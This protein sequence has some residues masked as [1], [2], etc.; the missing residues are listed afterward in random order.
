M[1]L[2]EVISN[3]LRPS[4][5]ELTLGIVHSTTDHRSQDQQNLTKETL[6]SNNIASDQANMDW[7]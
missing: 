1:H 7:L 2:A 3:F 4:E 5:H 6:Q